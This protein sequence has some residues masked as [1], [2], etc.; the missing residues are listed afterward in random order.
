MMNNRQNSFKDDNKYLLSVA[1]PTYNGARTIGK[2][3][4]TL[5]PQITDDVEVIISENCSTDGTNIILDEYQKKYTFIKVL[6]NKENIGPDNNFLKCISAAR[7][8]YVYLLSDDDIL[9]SGALKKITDYLRKYP[10]VS[11]VYLES[12]GFKGEYIGVE[13]CH[14]LRGYNK[15]IS[16]DIYSN[17][18]RVFL[19]YALRNWGFISSF[20]WKADKIK[21]ISAMKKYSDTFWIQSYFHIASIQNE[22]DYLGVIKGPCVAIGEYGNTNGLDVSVVDG[23]NYKAMLDFAI[24]TAYFDRKLIEKFYVWRLCFVGR[25]AIVKERVLGI[26]TTSE[27]HLFYLLKKKIYAWATLFPFFVLSKRTCFILLK[28]LRMIQGQKQLTFI[29]RMRT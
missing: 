29:N 1:I 16:N 10:D 18:R 23:D 4:K 17:D 2:L 20:L 7:G 28:I 21:D 3:L 5:L 19:N 14:K 25:R 11:L 13:K 6:R 22:E 15:K 24:E 12:V 8:K 27:K 26:H 9:V